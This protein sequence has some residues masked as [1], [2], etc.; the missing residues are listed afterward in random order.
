MSGILTRQIPPQT[1]EIEQR[2]TLSAF[3]RCRQ[4]LCMHVFSGWFYTLWNRLFVLLFA[5]RKAC[6]EKTNS[7]SYDIN[8]LNMSFAV[9][10]HI[11]KKATCEES[12]LKRLCKSLSSC[13]IS[14][15]NMQISIVSKKVNNNI[16][17]FVFAVFTSLNLQSCWQALFDFAALSVF[18]LSIFHIK[19]HIACR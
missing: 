6:A 1:F 11:H 14:N 9:H 4:Y 19:A 16:A 5:Q 8:Q 17:D 15:A 18:F 2:F 12:V 7:G 13:F 3:G 10:A